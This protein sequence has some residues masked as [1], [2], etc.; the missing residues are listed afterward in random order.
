MFAFINLGLLDKEFIEDLTSVDGQTKKRQE[1]VDRFQNSETSKVFL[2]SLKAGG[3]GLN[4][5]AADYCFLVDPWW[6]PAVESQAIDRC[7]RMGQ[8]RSVFAYRLIARQT[9]EEKILEL[10]KRTR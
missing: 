10:Q 5:T 1:L 8:Q 3:V 4:F 7:H 2:L 6:N 9:I